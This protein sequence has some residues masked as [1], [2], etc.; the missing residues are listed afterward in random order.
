[1][2]AMCF[3]PF[4]RIIHWGPLIAL[5][6]IKCITGMMIHCCGMWWPYN[7]LGGFINIGCFLSLSGLTFYNFL[8]A[9]LHG[10]G[11]L[12]LKWKPANKEDCKY[13]QYCTA[14]EGYKAPRSHHCRKCGRCVLKMDHH[15]PWINNCVGWGNHAHF[16]AFLMFAVLGCAQAFVEIGCSMY[17][18]LYTRGGDLAYYHYHNQHGAH[19]QLPP[20]VHMSLA[21]LCMSLFAFALSLSVVIAVGTLLFFQIRA[22]VTNRTGIE[23]WVLEKAIHRRKDAPQKF[24]FPYS[25]GVKRNIA[26]VVNWTCQP[27]GDGIFWNVADDCDQFTITREQLEQKNEKRSR[28]KVYSIVKSSTRSYCPI[29]QGIGVLFHPPCSD[30]SRIALSPGDKVSV[31]RWRPYWL[32]GDKIMPGQ[33]EGE[34]QKG[35]VRGWFPRHCAVDLVDNEY[36][37]RKPNGK[38][39]K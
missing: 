7:T 34:S 32:F 21:G 38:K 27:I 36:S 10:P 5:G 16:T 6:I 2:T 13:L 31:T 18:A 39:K 29:G 15:C 12:S 20:Q 19:I 23:D 11:Y 8:A 37:P 14:C 22:I 30:E 9:L 35:R 1:M 4:N 33:S 28:T 17:R 25:L 24:I 26:Q 3:G